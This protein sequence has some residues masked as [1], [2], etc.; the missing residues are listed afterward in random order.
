MFVMPY[1]CVYQSCNDRR[2]FVIGDPLEDQAVDLHLDYLDIIPSFSQQL[3]QA[4]ER[5]GILPNQEAKDALGSSDGCGYACL[6][7]FHCDL[8]PILMDEA[9]ALD[10]IPRH[11]IQDGSTYH[12]YCRAVDFFH[13]M[14]GL[15]RDKDVNIHS[16]EEHTIFVA[17][18]DRGSEIKDIIKEALDSNNAKKRD[19]FTGV[20]FRN[21][22]GR[23]LAILPSTKRSSSSTL[24]S[25]RHPRL[26][27]GQQSVNRPT[28]RPIHSIDDLFDDS[29]L[30]LDKSLYDD[31][32]P[33]L[34]S[35]K[36]IATYAL[37]ALGG[38]N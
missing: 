26:F 38:G 35:A 3:Y 29:S 8:N 33:N 7:T 21:S 13:Q 18:L 23:E 28:Q 27:P 19:K 2:G 14:N 12:A 24:S 31:S 32:V 5:D 9:D 36:N 17:G 30:L 6:Y 1:Y 15:I 16:K 4:L 22:V 10:L 34:S 25:S 37:E 20:Q 11:P